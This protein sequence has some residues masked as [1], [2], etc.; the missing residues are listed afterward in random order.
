MCKFRSES[1]NEL[2]P[3]YC[4]LSGGFTLI[5]IFSIEWSECIV[6]DVSM[7]SIIALLL[8]NTKSKI[9]FP[10]VG[11]V[12]HCINSSSS[13]NLFRDLAFGVKGWEFIFPNRFHVHSGMLKSP[14]ISISVEPFLSSGQFFIWVN[15][16]V[17]FS[18]E[19]F[20]GLYIFTG[21]ILL[22]FIFNRTIKNSQVP[23][24][25]F[26]TRSLCTESEM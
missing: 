7:F 11:C 18:R 15:V 16:L 1:G 26:D 25:S 9:F 6:G 12:T 3:L 20:G 24:E 23:F 5:S 17:N 10:L 19:Q 8:V 21:I 14:V 4:K 22:C 13:I 2:V